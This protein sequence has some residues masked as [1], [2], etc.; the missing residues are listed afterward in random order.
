MLLVDRYY[1]VEGKR[2]WK[3]EM[4]NAEKG[5]V[6]ITTFGHL[7][8]LWTPSHSFLSFH[9]GLFLHGI[10]IKHDMLSS[11]LTREVEE[12]PNTLVV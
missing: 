10:S 9:R 2:D 6:K 1:K 4:L 7:P 11:A 12:L 8:L 5:L 3:S